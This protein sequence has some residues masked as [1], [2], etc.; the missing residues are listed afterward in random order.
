MIARARRNSVTKR[1]MQR[2]LELLE[3]HHAI[4]KRTPPYC[5]QDIHDDL[6]GSLTQI[7]LL[8]ELAMRLLA[9]PTQ[10]AR[11]MAKITDSAR[12]NVRALDEI[13]WAVHPGS[14]NLNSLVALP[15]AI[16]RGIFRRTPMSRGR[17]DAPF[18]Y[19]RLSA[20]LATCA[21]LYFW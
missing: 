16:C 17:V 12:L 11:H 9:N 19:S 20:L 15:L 2:K 14:D 13:V 5:S 10:A 6:G 3:Q 1:R 8:G 21:T 7:A 4:E 18:L